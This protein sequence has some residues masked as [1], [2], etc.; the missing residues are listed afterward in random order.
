M[1]ITIL[2][3]YQHAVEKLDCFQLLKNQN[4]D[5]LHNTEKNKIILAE[6]LKDTDIIVLTRERTQINEELISLL[7]NLKLISQTGK[8]SNHLNIKLQFPKV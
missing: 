5:I 6:K 7:P 3:D 4:V 2:D 1:K 8:I